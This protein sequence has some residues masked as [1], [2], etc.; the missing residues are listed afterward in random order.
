MSVNTYKRGHV[1]WMED[2][3]DGPGLT[4]VEDS[5]RA[6]ALDAIWS[7]LTTAEKAEV[8]AWIDEQVVY[9]REHGMPKLEEGSLDL[10]PGE[11]SVLEYTGKFDL[12][13]ADDEHNVVFQIGQR[14]VKI[15]TGVLLDVDEGKSEFYIAA[16]DAEKL[17]L[18]N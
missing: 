18:L 16:E 17:G 2:R 5:A 13:V 10:T 11:R 8:K 7:E 12:I 9:R 6:E 15:S 4:D 3:G 1:R 14:E